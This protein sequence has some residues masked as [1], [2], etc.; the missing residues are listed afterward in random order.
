MDVFRIRG[1]PEFNKA[2][3][4]PTHEDHGMFF[5]RITAEKFYVS[6]PPGEAL[7]YTLKQIGL[8]FDEA[9]KILELIFTG[10]SKGEDMVGGVATLGDVAGDAAQDGIY[11][12]FVFIAVLSIQIAIINLLPIPLLDGGYLIFLAYEA[13]RGKPLPERVQDYAFS[14]GLFFIVGLAI[15]ANLT[16]IIKLF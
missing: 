12:F 3:S 9:F 11:T 4:D 2:L 6:H 1:L 7:R 14:A 5:S 13:L 16:D 8:F 10:G 15:F